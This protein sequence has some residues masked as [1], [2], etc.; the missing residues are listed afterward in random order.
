MANDPLTYTRRL[1]DILNCSNV[2]ILT[3]QC[4][5]QFTVD[6]L[7]NA[8]VRPPKYLA[9]FGPTVDSTRSVL[10]ETVRQSAPSC[11]ETVFGTTAL[12]VGVGRGRGADYLPQARLDDGLTSLQW[13]R[14]L[15]T[16]V[17][18]VYRYHQQKIYDILAHNY[19]DWDRTVDPGT[20]RDELVELI[21]DGQHV[22]PTVELAREHAVCAGATTFLFG[23][24][25]VGALSS[26]SRSWQSAAGPSEMAYVFGAPLADGIDPFG[27]T[28]VEQD[29]TLSE[30]VLSYWTSFVRTG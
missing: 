19:R 5:R 22:A 30:T 6:E 26:S 14:I 29:K 3:V 15:R 25:S 9:P 23:F 27:T 2:S 18:N 28:Y 8:D 4:L 13:T 16:Y 20:S 17:Q 24:D 12:L 1:A 10:P 21:G 11:R 7:V